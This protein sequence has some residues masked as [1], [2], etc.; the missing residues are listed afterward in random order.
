MTRSAC[1]TWSSIR[2]R[3]SAAFS[4]GGLLASGPPAEEQLAGTWVPDTEENRKTVNIG[5]DFIGFKVT[6]NADGTFEQSS[7][8]VLKGRWTVTGWDGLRALEVA[9]VVRESVETE[10]RAAM[11]HE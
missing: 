6:Y 1:L 4:G 10:V 9:H 7:L 3:C 2:R 11:A 5:A 8:I